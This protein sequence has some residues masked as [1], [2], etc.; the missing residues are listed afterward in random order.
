M[1]I[2]SSKERI[3][4]IGAGVMGE[5]LISLLTSLHFADV[6]IVEKR[7]ERQAQLHARYSLK[8]HKISEAEVVFLAVKP[9]DAS[10]ALQSIQK[11]IVRKTLIVSIIAGIKTQFIE[12]ALGELCRVIRVMP[13]TPMLYGEG[14]SVISPGKSAKREDVAWVLDLFSH[15]GKTLIV[16]ENLMDTVTAVSGSGPAYIYRFVEAMMS[17]ASKLGLN[18]EEAELLVTQTLV[19]AT[20]ML[21]ESGRD[22]STLRAEVSSPSGTTA[23]AITSFEASGFEEII[24][25]AMKAAMDRS[26]ELSN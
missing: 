9:K 26:K 22:A 2:I 20:K 24:Y 4:L 11:K 19:G 17:S 25:K 6:A 10:Q 18:K 8:S 3:S 21:Q 12:S 14:M 7:R 23:A 16:R 5:I 15:A 13:N 1:R